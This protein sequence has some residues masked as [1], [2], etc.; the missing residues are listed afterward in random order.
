MIVLCGQRKVINIY[1]HQTHY[2]YYFLES[3]KHIYKKGI[4]ILIFQTR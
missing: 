2:M 1:E 3:L 4:T